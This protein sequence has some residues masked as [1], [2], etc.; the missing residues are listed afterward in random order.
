MLFKI[1]T[2][3]IIPNQMFLSHIS[4]LY[5]PVKTFKKKVTVHETLNKTSPLYNKLQ[6]SMHNIQIE[7]YNILHQIL[8]ED[9]G[10]ER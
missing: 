5:A 6:F 3:M 1:V 9:I 10:F 7:C 2:V 4:V 8:G